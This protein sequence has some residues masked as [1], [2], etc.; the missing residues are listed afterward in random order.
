VLWPDALIGPW[1]AAPDGVS[2]NLATLGAVTALLTCTTGALSLVFRQLLAAKDEQIKECAE[3]AVRA[4][5][6][7]D[8]ERERGEAAAERERQRTDAAIAT[9]RAS[10]A[11]L[12]QA[13][14]HLEQLTDAAHANSGTNRRVGR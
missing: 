12:E 5:Q 2:L 14:G 1:Q 3:R 7:M 6:R 11:L 13:V 8:A 9:M 10:Q 4:E